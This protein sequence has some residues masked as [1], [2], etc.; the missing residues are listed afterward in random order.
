MFW[1]K[2]HSF[3]VFIDFWQA[4]IDMTLN[5][6]VQDQAVYQVPLEI[7]SDILSQVSSDWTI[8][9]AVFISLTRIQAILKT[10]K[11]Y[12]PW[13]V[14][15]KVTH[16]YTKISTLVKFLDSFESILQASFS[17]EIETFEKLC[18]NAAFLENLKMEAIMSWKL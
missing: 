10:H 3:D 11:L 1:L 4:M 16:E 13:K 18:D 14:V 9:L 8:M 17:L 7:V 15:S 6:C 2:I 5:T 12:V